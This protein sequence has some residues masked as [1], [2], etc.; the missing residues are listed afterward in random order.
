MI[1]CEFR[2]RKRT[3][4]VPFDE[5]TISNRIAGCQIGKT[6][7]FGRRRIRKSNAT[8]DFRGVKTGIRAFRAVQNFVQVIPHHQKRVHG[9]GRFPSL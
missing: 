1:R 4:T 7:H 9:R 3:R 2:F 6:E 5:F 8:S